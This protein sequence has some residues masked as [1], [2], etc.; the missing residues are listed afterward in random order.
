MAKW[1]IDKMAIWQ[2][3]S[4]TKWQFDKMAQQ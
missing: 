3:G 1:Q 2:N 4:L